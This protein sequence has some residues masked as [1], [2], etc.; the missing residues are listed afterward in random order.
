MRVRHPALAVVTGLLIPIVLGAALVVSTSRGG[1]GVSLGQAVFEIHRVDRAVFP[2][3]PGEPFFVLV[4]GTDERPGLAGSRADAIHLIG[5]NVTSGQATILNIPRDTWVN[6][7]GYGMNKINAAHQFGGARLQ[8]ETVAAFVGVDIPYVISTGFEGLTAMVDEL[9]GVTVDVPI[10][11][12]DANSGA[13]FDAGPV[14]MDGFGALAFSRNRGV[15]G[16][17][18][19]RTEH[20]ALLIMAGL[21][22]L[23]SE[24]ASRTG[25]LSH[26]AALLRHGRF[27]GVS[28]PDLYRLGRLAL[29]IDPNNVRSVTMPGFSGN[30]GGASA[31]FAAG[32][33]Q[34]L[35][36]DLADDA[37]LQ[38][39]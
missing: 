6:I 10:A 32:G 9:G 13:Y 38:S 1:P 11:M 37:V 17:D 2:N 23:R 24:D 16:G 8:A 25:T 4:L 35:F 15:P 22:K 12:A 7:P 21:A 5:V 26:L 39:H 18:F 14:H 30:A 36:A 33:A 29:A 28:V 19:R 31:V 27:E 3:W 34:S 20:Q